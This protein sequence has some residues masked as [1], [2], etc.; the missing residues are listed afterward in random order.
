M[1]R[2]VVEKVV[3]SI[4][5]AQVCS[6]TENHLRLW[7]MGLG[8]C[9]FRIT[10]DHVLV[11]DLSTYTFAFVPLQTRQ[12]IERFVFD[13]EVEFFFIS[14]DCLALC[15]IRVSSVGANLFDDQ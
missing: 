13:V 3:V 10:Y 7:D 9:A 5:C 1:D 15:T 8:L 4:E 12:Q 14:K 6:S 2:G 11:L